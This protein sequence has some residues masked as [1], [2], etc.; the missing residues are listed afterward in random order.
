MTSS[1]LLLLS[2][3]RLSAQSAVGFR[4]SANANVAFLLLSTPLLLYCLAPAW[5]TVHGS[6]TVAPRRTSGQR[7]TERSG[8]SMIVRRSKSPSPQPSPGVPGEGAGTAPARNFLQSRG[9]LL[10]TVNGSVSNSPSWGLSTLIGVPRNVRK[11]Q[12][13]KVDRRFQGGARGEGL[14]FFVCKA[15]SSKGVRRRRW[16]HGY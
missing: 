15:G 1:G 7:K 2:H 13:R 16:P 5:R 8:L 4:F 6:K 14:H 11:R 12:K 10:S 9:A 3:P